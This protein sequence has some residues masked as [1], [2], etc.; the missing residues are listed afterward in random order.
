MSTISEAGSRKPMSLRFREDLIGVLKDEA[1]KENRSLNNFLENILIQYFNVDKKVPNATTL[2]AMREAEE[3]NN[4]ETLDLDNF[5]EYV[6][7]L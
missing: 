7:S 6:K 3:D 4:L 1:K 5:Q 2:A